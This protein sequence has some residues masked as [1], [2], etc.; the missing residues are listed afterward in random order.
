MELDAVIL[1]PPPELAGKLALD[2]E[3]MG[4]GGAWFPEAEH[5]PYLGAAL[6]ASATSTIGLGTAIALAFPRSPMIT[7]QIAWDLSRLSGGRF[8]LGLGPQVKVQMEQRFSVPFSQPVP[9]LR[10]YCLALR[11]IFDAFQGRSELDFHGEF[12]TFTLLTEEFSGGPIPEPDIPIMISGLSENLA[13]AAAQVGDGFLAHAVH[14]RAYLHDVI[15]PAID[16]ELNSGNALTKKEF[17]VGVPV[18]CVPTGYDVDKETA[19]IETIRKRL[20]F[21]LALYGDGKSKNYNR[22]LEMHDLPGLAHKLSELQVGG[23]SA[24]EMSALITDDVLDIFAV[25]RPWEEIADELIYRYKGA[26]DRVILYGAPLPSWSKD[27]VLRERVA[28]IAG[29]LRDA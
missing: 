27:P 6:A 21:Y 23:A 17:T 4:L 10:E 7:A 8:M 3:S 13:R 16:E 11:A 5:N 19:R 28:T 29:Q 24:N 22:I 14:S 18:F 1:S 15:R 9:R 26:V 2:A 12:Y 20:A 25:V